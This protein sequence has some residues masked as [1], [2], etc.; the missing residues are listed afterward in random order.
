MSYGFQKDPQLRNEEYLRWV[1][2]QPSVVSLQIG[3]HAHHVVGHG[4][5]STIKTH[6]YL[7][8]PLTRAEHALLHDGGWAAWEAQYG[9]QK[10]HSADMLIEAIKRGVLKFDANAAKRDMT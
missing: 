10:S 6:D 2:N 3:V 8:I 4:R 7:A 1:R 9:N 5:C